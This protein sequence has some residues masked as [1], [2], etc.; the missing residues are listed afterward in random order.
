MQDWIREEH[1]GGGSINIFYSGK[2]EGNNGTI[3]AN[4]GASIGGEGGNAGGT[5]GNGAISIGSVATGTYV[6]YNDE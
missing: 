2:Y 3:T 5:G 6:S 1:H 4:G